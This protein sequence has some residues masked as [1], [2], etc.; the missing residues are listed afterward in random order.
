[1]SDLVGNPEDRFS[2]N[3]AYMFQMAFQFCVWDRFKELGYLGDSNRQNLG[4]L[5]THL[6]A[7]KAMSLSIFKVTHRGQHM[8]LIKQAFGEFNN[9]LNMD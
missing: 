8:K 5:L 9:K 2:Y 6:L 7:A 3:V 1:M 4:K